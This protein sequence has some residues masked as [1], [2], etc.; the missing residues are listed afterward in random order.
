MKAY[1]CDVCGTLYRVKDSEVTI[2]LPSDDVTLTGEMKFIV[3]RGDG[4]HVIDDLCPPCVRKMA[5]NR[6]LI[7][8]PEDDK[9]DDHV[10]IED[11]DQTARGGLG[12][13]KRKNRSSDDES[14]EGVPV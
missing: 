10:N 4:D 3:E 5:E 6:T 2:G 13:K 1:E 14:E 9:R 11:L 12:L 8:T 7:V